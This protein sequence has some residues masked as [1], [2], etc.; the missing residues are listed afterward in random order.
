MNCKAIGAEPVAQEGCAAINLLHLTNHLRGC[1]LFPM[2]KETT[3]FQSS[4]LELSIMLSNA[5]ELVPIATTVSAG[6]PGIA[7][8]QSERHGPCHIGHQLVANM[9][10]I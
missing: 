1:R 4:A 9:L 2:I 5:R 10:H 6:R 8:T 7:P 3:A